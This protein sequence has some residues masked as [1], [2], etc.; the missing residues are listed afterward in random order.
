MTNTQSL[1]DKS[2]YSHRYTV[3]F[4]NTDELP[5]SVKKFDVYSYRMKSKGH[6]QIIEV[7]QLVEETYLRK[8]ADGEILCRDKILDW[9]F[10]EIDSK[11]GE[12]AKHLI[13]AQKGVTGL[14]KRGQVLQENE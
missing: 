14:L 6:K 4:I 10:I 2:G 12:A 9:R 13:D 7:F 1:K 5:E 11:Y 3:C 8:D